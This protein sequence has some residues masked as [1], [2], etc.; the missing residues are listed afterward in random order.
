MMSAFAPTEKITIAEAY[1]W[2]RG[3]AKSLSD[4]EFSDVEFDQFRPVGFKAPKKVSAKRKTPTDQERMEMDYDDSL[5]DGRVWLSGGYCCQ[6]SQKKKGDSALCTR[7]ITEAGKHD[8]EL[9]NGLI[10]GERP[11]H[12]YG[13][14]SQKMIPWHDV[15]VEKVKKVKKTSPVKASGEKKK[16]C[17]SVC[18]VAGHTKAK[19]PQKE[20]VESPK[21]KTVKEDSGAGVG[22]V[23]M[24]PDDGDTVDMEP[25]FMG[26][27]LEDNSSE[28][29]DLDESSEM[30]ELK[31]DG[32]V[33]YRTVN[34]EVIDDDTDPVGKWV[35]GEITLTSLGKR[36][37]KARLAEKGE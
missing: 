33:Y 26:L 10:T 35:D 19:C 28:D 9:K 13:D 6:C 14:S 17:C 21:S 22:L 15:V 24:G 32:L 37:H 30:V 2:I 12:H 31:L 4:G 1:V 18:G 16:R 36:A 8:G 34:N 25:L 20:S 23:D 5:C 7:H 29:L 3:M 11:T 27:S